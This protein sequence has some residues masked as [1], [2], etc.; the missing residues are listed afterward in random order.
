M[1]V[2]R[3]RFDDRS[4]PDDEVAYRYAGTVYRF[5]SRG[6]A[7]VARSYDDTP[8]RI[9]FL[10]WEHA[11][12]NGRPRGRAFDAAV[13]YA[14]ERLGKTDVRFLGPRGYVRVEG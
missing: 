12:F 4:E 14:R 5:E 8:E 6:R 2:T 13:R 3:E 9:S 1:T 7:L 10:R 11:R